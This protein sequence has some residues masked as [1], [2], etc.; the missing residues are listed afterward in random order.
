MNYLTEEE[1]KMPK[2]MALLQ[3]TLGLQTCKTKKDAVELLEDAFELGRR[4]ERKF[5]NHI[6]GHFEKDHPDWKVVCKICGKSHDEIV[7]EGVK[8]EKKI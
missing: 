3:L 2:D 4:R 7:N 6:R 1:S 5:H 8:D